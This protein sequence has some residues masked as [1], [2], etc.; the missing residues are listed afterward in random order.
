MSTSSAQ[1]KIVPEGKL[2]IIVWSVC[3]NI[4]R[5]AIRS[6]TPAG[7][8]THVKTD[9]DMEP[10]HTLVNGER[11][12]SARTINDRKVICDT[13]FTALSSRSRD[14]RTSADPDF[15]ILEDMTILKAIFKKAPAA[16]APKAFHQ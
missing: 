13:V 10:L 6:A 5:N 2:K 14:P 8:M 15:H 7:E 16:S 11:E 3:T 9:Q 12:R 4:H 1:D